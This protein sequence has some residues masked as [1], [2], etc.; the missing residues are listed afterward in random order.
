MQN[1]GGK[2]SV[3]W[4]IGKQSIQQV[5]RGRRN[6]NF[7]PM[8]KQRQQPSIKCSLL[9]APNLNNNQFCQI[10]FAPKKVQACSKIIGKKLDKFNR[11]SRMCEQGLERSLQSQA[12]HY[13]PRTISGPPYQAPPFQALPYQTPHFRPLTISGPPHQAP[14]SKP[15]RSIRG[16]MLIIITRLNNKNTNDND[17]I[18][19]NNNQ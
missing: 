16:P 15:R 12:P 1:L 18:N 6:N 3:L 9:H 14:H 13:R 5:K 7:E 11:S 10:V 19:N 4:A 2:Q 8:C 17:N